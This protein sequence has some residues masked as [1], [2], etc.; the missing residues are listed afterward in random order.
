MIWP[1]LKRVVIKTV[2]FNQRSIRQK[3]LSLLNTSGAIAKKAFRVN[4]PSAGE[5]S[6]YFGSHKLDLAVASSASVFI[7]WPRRNYHWFSHLSDT[8]GGIV[9]LVT[10][11]RLAFLP[12]RPP[13]PSPRS[14]V[15]W[16]R[17][18]LR[19]GQVAAAAVW[20]HSIAPTCVMNDAVCSLK[21]SLESGRRVSQRA[22]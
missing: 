21:V 5:W 2:M 13:F 11:E 19:A 16:P 7:M 15:G 6:P 8:S 20:L 12:R 10:P 22:R 17:G 1:D 14:R 4:L 9:P 18:A 3:L